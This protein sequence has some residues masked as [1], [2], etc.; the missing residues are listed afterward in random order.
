MRTWRLEAT[1]KA[2]TRGSVVSLAAG[3]SFAGLS[4]SAAAILDGPGVLAVHLRGRQ[5][6]RKPIP[7]VSVEALLAWIDEL[8]STPVSKRESRIGR[9][10][11][12]IRQWLLPRTDLAS[13]PE[14][15]MRLLTGL[16]APTLGGS[17]TCG[18]S[19]PAIT[20][21]AAAWL[22]P[23]AGVLAPLGVVDVAMDWS[24]KN[25]LEGDIEASC[26]LVPVRGIYEILRF[27]R[28]H[29]HPLRK[30]VAAPAVP[31]TLSP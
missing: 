16:R 15:G 25:I 22:Y 14:L 7:R 23:V 12:R 26:G 19:D 17:I 3:L 29:V 2:S 10:L 9:I 6:W 21:A 18:F 4:A 24:G 20:G 30:A 8:I 5:L 13:L 27:L 31:S 28:L 11:G 1:L